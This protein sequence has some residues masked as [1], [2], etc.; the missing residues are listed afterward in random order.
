MAQDPIY[1]PRGITIESQGGLNLS[2][3]QE[4]VRA[5]QRLQGRLNQLS[6]LAFSKMKEKAIREGKQY[7]VENRPSGEQLADAV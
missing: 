7:G 2:N 1:K 3:V 4:S 5:S 6:D